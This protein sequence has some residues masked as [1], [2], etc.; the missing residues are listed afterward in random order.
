MPLQSY[1]A[2]VRK[3]ALCSNFSSG[4]AAG[5]WVTQPQRI[6]VS[7]V[8]G[9]SPVC[10]IAR[11]TRR[12]LT[13]RAPATLLHV[14][15]AASRRLHGRMASS[16]GVRWWPASNWRVRLP[17]SDSAALNCLIDGQN[18]SRPPLRSE[19]LADRTTDVLAQEVAAG[20]G[21]K[22]LQFG[23]SR[24][25]LAPSLVQPTH[26]NAF[27]SFRSGPISQQLTI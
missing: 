15:S 17:S 18:F 10:P 27:S 3:L 6:S 9:P 7:A 14:S 22:A 19:K 8:T 16:A 24:G 20:P 13:G 21:P 12:W 1:P 4:T 5:L 25:S 23:S 11:R 2:R 26:T